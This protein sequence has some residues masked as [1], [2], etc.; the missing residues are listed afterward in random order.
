MSDVGNLLQQ[1]RRGRFIGVIVVTV[2][3]AGVCWY[4]GMDVWHSATVGIGSA[5]V[6]LAWVALPDHRNADWPDDH[7]LTITSTGGGPELR[8][9]SALLLPRYGRVRRESLARVRD[10]AR[11]RLSLRQLDLDD[12]SHRLGIEQLIGSVAYVTLCQPRRRPLLR[13]VVHCLDALD[14]LDPSRSSPVP[15]VPLLDLVRSSILRKESR[16]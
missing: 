9:L 12:P 1:P 3:A 7:A 5:A 11:H 2:L 16:R 6:G 13:S 8:R 15:R 4:I 10:L 14:R